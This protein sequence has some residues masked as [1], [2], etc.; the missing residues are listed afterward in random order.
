MLGCSLPSLILL[1]VH[2]LLRPSPGGQVHVEVVLSQT[3][4]VGQ[5]ASEVHPDGT[6]TLLL[7]H[8][9]EGGGMWGAGCACTSLCVE[10]CCKD[11]AATAP[12]ARGERGDG[13]IGSQALRA[14]SGVG[15]AG[16]AVFCRA[17]AVGRGGC[18]WRVAGG[19]RE[20]VVTTYP[21]LPLQLS[22]ALVNKPPLP[23]PQ[24]PVPPPHPHP[25][26]T[27][28]PHTQALTG[29]GGRRNARRLQIAVLARG[30]R[31]V[32]VAVGVAFGDG[33]AAL[34]AG[35]GG[36]RARCDGGGGAR[37]AQACAWV[38]SVA[39]GDG[40]AGAACAVGR[41]VGLTVGQGWAALKA[42]AIDDPGGTVAARRA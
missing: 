33:D 16:I 35:G 7:R 19:Q 25:P 40:G 8:R 15:A 42:G 2:T 9:S 27:P 4:L 13:G 31:A 14:V 36:P 1:R 6:H 5:P 30:A 20:Q 38:L 21:S 22:F 10:Q 32:N 29:A 34:L 17:A 18:T 11:S 41:N 39:V 37:G 23:S 3:L 12:P 28:H 24:P 26:P